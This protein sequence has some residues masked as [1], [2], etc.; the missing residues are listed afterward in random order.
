[1]GEVRPEPVV[2]AS[3]AIGITVT[4]GRRGSTPARPAPR[5]APSAGAGVRRPVASGRLIDLDKRL[6][7]AGGRT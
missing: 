6:E 5:E 7:A 2:P 1:M 3:S 4:K